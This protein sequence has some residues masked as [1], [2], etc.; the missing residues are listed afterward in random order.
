MDS[1]IHI[2]AHGEG[3]KAVFNLANFHRSIR[4]SPFSLSSER[5][6]Y[7]ITQEWGLDAQGKSS[8]AFVPFKKGTDEDLLLDLIKSGDLK[9]L[10]DAGWVLCDR[11]RKG[12]IS[13]NVSVYNPKTNY[14]YTVGGIGLVCS[15]KEVSNFTLKNPKLTREFEE[16]QKKRN[17][18][19]GGCCYFTNDGMQF[20]GNDCKLGVLE[21]AT[22]LYSI[23][24]KISETIRFGEAGINVPTYI[25][26]GRINNLGDGKYEFS[27]Y[28]SQLNPEY[29]I[30]ID[31]FMDEKLSFT[32][33]FKTYIASKYQQLSRIH[34][35]LG[36]S[37]AQPTATNALLELRLTDNG[38]E[39]LC[40]IKDFDTNRPLPS[41]KQRSIEDGICAI[42]LGFTVKKSPYLAAI[43]YDLQIAITQELNVLYLGIKMITDVNQA[44]QFILARSAELTQLISTS[45]G[46]D[47]VNLSNTINFSHNVF[48]EAIKKGSSIDAYTQILGGAIANGLFAFGKE[49]ATQVEISK[50]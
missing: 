20:V 40:Q 43:I 8:K 31:L 2:E 36:E 11:P 4:F 26:A 46:L 42:P 27:I 44:L 5:D 28:R 29:M 17:Q 38:I 6:A 9:P 13:R 47:S 3:K 41:A 21:F 22:G 45:Y 14:C 34:H 15:T 19:V 16:Y 30:N 18:P 1:S 23:E 50:H 32:P 12:G 37:H 39:P 35:T 25:A 24:R 48:V 10:T 33:L 7:E 49:F